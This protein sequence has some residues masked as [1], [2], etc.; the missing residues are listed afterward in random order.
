MK[1][2]RRGFLVCSSLLMASSFTYF[3]NTQSQLASAPNIMTPAEVYTALSAGELVL[4]D[5]RRPDEWQETGIASG[6]V[7]IDVR[8]EDFVQAVAD[9][10]DRTSLPVAVICARGVRSWRTTTALTE[11]GFTQIFDVPEGML[12]SRAGPGWIASNYPII[13]WKG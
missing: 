10:R 6:A 4:I 1:V 8:R 5:I 2:S 9:I 12:G 13:P 3:K 7:P 11:A